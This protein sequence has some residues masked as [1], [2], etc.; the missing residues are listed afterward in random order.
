MNEH[1]SG[2]IILVL[3]Y[4]FL[5]GFGLWGICYFAKLTKERWEEDE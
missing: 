2:L 4:L 1:I 3:M 5:L